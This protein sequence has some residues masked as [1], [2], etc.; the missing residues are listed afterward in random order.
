MAKMTGKYIYDTTQGKVVKI[1]D[2]PYI[3]SATGRHS[4][5]FPSHGTKYFDPQ[6]QRVFHSKTEKRAWMREK[7][8]VETTAGPN[9]LKGLAESRDCSQRKHFTV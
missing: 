7:N 3:T 5:W 1:S 4:C 2:V 6:A 8:V 9:P